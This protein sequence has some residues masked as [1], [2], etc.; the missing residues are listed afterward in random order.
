MPA[1]D[2]PEVIL[3]PVKRY[4]INLTFDDILTPLTRTESH[5]P[6]ARS[7]TTQRPE[8]DQLLQQF[9]DL[10]R[11]LKDVIARINEIDPSVLAPKT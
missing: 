1:D 5:Q 2:A 9:A 3:V 6:A 11:Q 4:D 8:L 7:V 10:A